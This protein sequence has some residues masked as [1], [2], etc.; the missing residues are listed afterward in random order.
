MKALS[1]AEIE[2]RKKFGKVPVKH[3]MYKTPEHNAW[4][5]MRARC[6]NPNHPCYHHYGGRGI[7]VCQRWNDF[8]AFISDMGF[9][10]SPKHSIER[11]NNELGYTP[12]NCCWIPRSK[13]TSNTRRTIWIDHNGE[14]VPL[15]QYCALKDLCYGTVRTRLKLG[16][17]L[18]DAV[19]IPI[20]SQYSTR[21]SQNER[22]TANEGH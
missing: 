7:K 21:K 2:R 5:A 12:E 22:T 18:S 4:L 9:R 8:G 17:T 19:T 15:K 14:R 6:S 10:P 20:M 16:W 11:I 13:Q 1:Q 3:G